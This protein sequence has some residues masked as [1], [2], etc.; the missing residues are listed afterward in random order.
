MWV[1]NLQ[2]SQFSLGIR[3]SQNLTS[4]KETHQKIDAGCVTCAPIK[5]PFSNFSSHC[6]H[7]PYVYICALKQPQIDWQVRGNYQR[8]NCVVCVSFGVNSRF[9][10]RYIQKKAF[11]SAH[12]QSVASAELAY[13]PIYMKAKLGE[14]AL[15]D[16]GASRTIRSLLHCQSP[17][18]KRASCFLASICLGAW[19][20]KPDMIQRYNQGVIFTFQT[21][22][23]QSG[24]PKLGDWSLQ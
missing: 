10:D 15:L 9:C 3:H 4:W 8:L 12:Q 23:G 6:V 22:C 7:L 11:E 14:K 2:E 1:R 16:V 5:A 20:L 13:Q 17:F 24:H 18:E 19:N 21:A